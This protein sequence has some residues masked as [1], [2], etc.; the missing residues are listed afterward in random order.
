[1]E[2]QRASLVAQMVKNPPAMQETWGQSLGWEDPLKEVMAT[3]SSILTWRIPMDRGT[4]WATVHG[5]SKSR[6]RLKRLSSSSSSSIPLGA[7]QVVL[8]VKNPPSN[9]GDTRDAG[10][11]PGSG[12]S[13]GGRHGNPLQYSYLE[14]HYG[15]MSLAGYSPWY[16]KESDTTE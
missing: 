8:V 13:P 11:I 10:S 16:C 12:R 1:M 15:Q 5:I 2:S 3:H 6:T 9:A 7:S 14:N 4:W